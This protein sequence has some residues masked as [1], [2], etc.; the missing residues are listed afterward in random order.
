MPGIEARA[1]ERTETSSGASASPKRR[2]ITFSILP[3]AASAS[4]FT[5]SGI[6]PPFF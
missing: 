4:R 5:A 1:P 3:S 2:P 6:R